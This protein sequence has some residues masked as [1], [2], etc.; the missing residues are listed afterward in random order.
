MKNKKIVVLEG[1]YNE[2]HEISIATS[3]EIKK[4]LIELNHNVETVVVNPNNFIKKINQYDAEIFFNALHGTFGEDGTIQKI[5]FNLGKKFTHSGINASKIAFDKN[6]TKKIIKNTKVNF[7]DSILINNTEINEKIFLEIFK[8]IGSFII[9]PISSGSSYGV[10]LLDSK[11]NIQSFFQNNFNKKELYK[12]HHKLLIERYIQ[13]KELTVSVIET[14]K[15]SKAIE[16]TEIISNNLFFDYQAKY[17]KGISEHIL[18]A[19]IPEEIYTRCLN[20]SKLVH[21]MIGC[22]GISRSDF[23]YNE[24]NKELYFLEINTQPGLTQLSLVPEQ[25]KFVNI[26]FITLIE[27]LLVA[28]SC[29]E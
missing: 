7:L 6:L 20:E 5:L 21:D 26:D 24:I 8:K 11:E 22:R 1:G 27:K 15:E 12:N 4:A 2:E 23:I 10:Q 9:K 29:Q 16:V 3:E 14:N 17:T 18:P 13:G 25:L 28:S 19:E